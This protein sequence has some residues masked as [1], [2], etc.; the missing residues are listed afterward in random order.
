MSET[1]LL[2]EKGDV[3]KWDELWSFVGAKA[4]ERWLWIAWYRQT[5]HEERWNCTLRQRLGRFVRETLFSKGERMHELALR[6]FIHHYNQP[7][8]SEQKTTIPNW[9]KSS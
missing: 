1:L 6:L 4:N 2:A 5:R 8:I 3:L 7:P 9:I